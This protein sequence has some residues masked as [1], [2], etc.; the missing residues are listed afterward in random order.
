MNRDQFDRLLAPIL[1]LAY[2]YAQRLTGN[3]DDGM[4]LLQDATIDAWKGRE[5]FE[6]GTHFKAWFFK[7]ITNRFY[8]LKQK[9][10]V[11]TV[12]IEE[13]SEKSSGDLNGALGTN[14][15][16]DPALLALQKLESE[17]VQQAM[18]DLPDE[19]RTA[20]ALYFLADMSYEEISQTLDVPIGTVRSRLH[21]GRKLLQTKLIEFAIGTVSEDVYA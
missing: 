13:A 7:I 21:R 18:D 10:G 4:D 19:F 8:R 20:A 15:R 3:A 9:R 5:S 11:A 16:S 6:P 12:S 17:K 14:D 2:R 1:P